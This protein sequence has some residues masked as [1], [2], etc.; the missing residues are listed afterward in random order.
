MVGRFVLLNHLFMSPLLNKTLMM[1]NIVFGMASIFNGS[2]LQLIQMAIVLSYIY[3][4][5]QYNECMGE[6]M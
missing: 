6:G 1:P 4:D 3:G 2:E 5:N